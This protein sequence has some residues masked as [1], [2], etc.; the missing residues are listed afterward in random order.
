MR[1]EEMERRCL[2]WA[3]WKLGGGS[4]STGYARVSPGMEPGG[5]RYREAKI[6]TLDC[7]AEETDRAIMALPSELRRTIEV[8]YQ[9]QHGYLLQAVE[10]GVAQAMMY[11]RVERAHALMA[12]WLSERRRSADDERRRV[13]AVQA[14]ARR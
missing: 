4:G 1:D 3:R 9:S 7:E 13:Q 14:S 2:N 11:R 10:L 6:P 5:G 12:A 8:V